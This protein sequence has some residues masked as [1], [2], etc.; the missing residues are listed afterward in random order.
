MELTVATIGTKVVVSSQKLLCITLSKQQPWTP[1][2]RLEFLSSKS[3]ISPHF[4]QVIVVVI[5]EKTY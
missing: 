1:L 2:L 5:S 3:N 4:L